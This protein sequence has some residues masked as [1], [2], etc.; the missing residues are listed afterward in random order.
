MFQLEINEI[1]VIYLPVLKCVYSYQSETHVDSNIS[2][3]SGTFF[4]ML[5]NWWI[6]GPCWMALTLVDFRGNCIETP[7]LFFPLPSSLP[8]M[9]YTAN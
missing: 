6:Q 5:Q 1:E 3:Q 7:H 8:Q 9:V 4:Y 2:G